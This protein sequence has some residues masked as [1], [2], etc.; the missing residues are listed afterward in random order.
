MS[1]FSKLILNLGGGQFILQNIIFF[2]LQIKK[3]E[4]LC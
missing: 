2:N 1:G 4:M 3:F